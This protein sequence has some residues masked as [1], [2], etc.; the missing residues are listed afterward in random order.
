MTVAT[1]AAQIPSS[2]FLVSNDHIRDANLSILET[3][4]VYRRE[5]RMCGQL[6][7][8]VNRTIE[9]LTVLWF[10][11]CLILCRPPAFMARG[12]RVGGREICLK[13]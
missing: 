10:A 12:R 1:A 4:G 2:V 5:L 7:V 9:P 6:A 13:K 3:I 8:E 11:I